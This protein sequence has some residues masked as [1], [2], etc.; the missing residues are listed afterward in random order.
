MGQDLLNKDGCQLSGKKYLCPLVV[1]AAEM[2]KHPAFL[3]VPIIGIFKFCLF[4]F[5]LWKKGIIPLHR[6]PCEG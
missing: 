6:M 1:V 3:G 5:N 2:A 4:F